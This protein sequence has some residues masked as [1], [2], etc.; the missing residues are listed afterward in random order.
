[1]KRLV[2]PAAALLAVGSVAMIGCHSTGQKPGIDAHTSK[3]VD[4][5]WP[6]RYNATARQEVLAPF[7]IQVNNAAI[8]DATIWNHYFEPETDT[9]LPS[10]LQK[11]NYLVHRRPAPDAR[12]YLQTT[13]DVKYDPTKPEEYVTKRQELDAKRAQAVQRIAVLIDRR[14]CPRILRRR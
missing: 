2:R 6:E 5:C 11:L 8:L 1:M 4:P 9:L 10:G 7:A 14:E 12:V 3:Y 13:H